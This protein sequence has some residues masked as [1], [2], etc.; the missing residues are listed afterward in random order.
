[1]DGELFTLIEH[2]N[3]PDALDDKRQSRLR[4]LEARTAGQQ[5]T[6]EL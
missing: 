5:S 3:S 2:L 6:E 1:M 4:E